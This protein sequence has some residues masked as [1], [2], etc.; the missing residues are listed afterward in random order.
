MTIEE[1]WQQ[2]KAYYENSGYK[3]SIN[4]NDLPP[5]R[6]FRFAQRPTDKEIELLYNNS[7]KL[8]RSLQNF[9][10][11]KD[12]LAERFLKFRGLVAT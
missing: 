2:V 3:V 4:N 1:K 10:A 6:P 12:F 5:F 11:N 9:Y 8:Q 7:L